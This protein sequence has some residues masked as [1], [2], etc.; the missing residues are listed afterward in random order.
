MRTR[1]LSAA[2]TNG[3]IGRLAEILI[4]AV[5]SGAS[6]GFLAPLSVDRAE[7]FWV[8]AAAEVADGQRI[9]LVSEVADSVVG[10]VSVVRSPKENSAHRV[11]IA[12]LLVHRSARQLGVGTELMAAADLAALEAGATLAMLDTTAG[13]TAD[14]L[15]RRLGWTALGVVPNHAL[16]PDGTM[17]DTTFFYKTLR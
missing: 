4:D 5:D 2:E 12:K 11:E 1:V 14:R 3:C 8:D 7:R 13:S 15:Y 10:T 16:Y 9:L 17:S 6:V